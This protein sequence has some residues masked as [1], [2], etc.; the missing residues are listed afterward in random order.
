MTGPL[1]GRGR[2]AGGGG[3]T[4]PACPPQRAAVCTCQ[5]PTQGSL[6]CRWKPVALL[7]MTHFSGF[8]FF[9]LL[10]PFTLL[11]HPPMPLCNNERAKTWN[12]N[13]RA[14]PSSFVLAGGLTECGACSPPTLPLGTLRSPET[15]GDQRVQAG[16]LVLQPQL[17]VIG[18]CDRVL[19][20]APHVQNVTLSVTV[21]GCPHSGFWGGHCLVFG[22]TEGRW[23]RPL[24]TD[25]G[26]PG[27]AQ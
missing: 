6:R 7:V 17:F 14:F 10:G 24:P 11:S 9:K 12:V 2:G 22:R 4:A 21:T 18:F 27:R 16:H 20:E 3:Q 23:Q 13:L 15:L 25:Q 26:C 5:R 19:A 1:L 8:V